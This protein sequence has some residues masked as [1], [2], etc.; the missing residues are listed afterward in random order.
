MFCA[1]NFPRHVVSKVSGLLLVFPDLICYLPFIDVTELS[2]SNIISCFSF[3]SYYNPY[4]IYYYSD[5]ISS[6]IFP[7]SSSVISF[8]TILLILC[9]SVIS[10]VFLVLIRLDI[11]FILFCIPDYVTVFSHI[12]YQVIDFIIANVFLLIFF[13]ISFIVINIYFIFILFYIICFVV[14]FYPVHPQEDH[15][16]GK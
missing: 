2:Y 1:Y 14:I 9:R 7:P 16:W 15:H 6:G 13:Y 12:W 4:L 8:L 5:W 10:Y 11:I 3:L